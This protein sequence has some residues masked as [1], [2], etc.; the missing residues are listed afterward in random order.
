MVLL[1]NNT[2][3]KPTFA[4]SVAAATRFGTN[5]NTNSTRHNGFVND[6]PHQEYII[7]ADAAVTKL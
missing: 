7:K 6:D 1:R 5:P 2:T 4:N 3:S